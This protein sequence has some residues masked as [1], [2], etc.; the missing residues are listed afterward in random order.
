MNGILNSNQSTPYEYDVVELRDSQL[1][2]K[3][4]DDIK[5]YIKKGTIWSAFSSKEKAALI[6]EIDKVDIE[7]PNDLLHEID[8]MKFLVYETG[9]V[10]SAKTSNCYYNF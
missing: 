4:V 1:G 9:E 7:F 6:D 8:K 10:I 5:N 2:D 3:K